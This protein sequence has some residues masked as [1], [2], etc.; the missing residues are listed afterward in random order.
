MKLKHAALVSGPG[1]KK[2]PRVI[3]ETEAV[4]DWLTG[5]V[6]HPKNCAANAPDYAALEQRILSALTNEPFESERA[7]PE[8]D[9]ESRQ[10]MELTKGAKFTAGELQT[11]TNRFRGPDLPPWLWSGK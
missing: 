4:E 7:L 10:G 3:R 11:I 1:L 8:F 2:P 9:P 5:I 6:D